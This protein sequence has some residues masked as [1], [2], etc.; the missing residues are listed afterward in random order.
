MKSLDLS[1]FSLC[2]FSFLLRCF[3][4]MGLILSFQTFPRRKGRQ[5]HQ[6]HQQA[7]PP[8]PPRTMF[9]N[10]TNF[11]NI[12]NTNPQTL[13]PRLVLLNHP[14]APSH[15]LC[16]VA[17]WAQEATGMCWMPSFRSFQAVRCFPFGIGPKHHQKDKG[18]IYWTSSLQKSKTS[19]YDF[20]YLVTSNP[21][22]SLHRQQSTQHQDNAR[23]SDDAP[24]LPCNL[25]EQHRICCFTQKNG[26]GRKLN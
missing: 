4:A 2:F 13:H 21:A 1:L 7:P 26:S 3:P 5:Q 12:W 10:V 18:W 25:H 16:R 20:A 15:R 22:N 11:W 19:W 24:G 8:Q 6:Q 9:F 14:S 17:S 23:T